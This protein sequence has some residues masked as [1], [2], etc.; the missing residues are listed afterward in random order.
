MTSITEAQHNKNRIAV[1][2]TYLFAWCGRADILVLW[3][4]PLAI[5]VGNRTWHYHEFLFI[6]HHRHLALDLLT[7]YLAVSGIHYAWRHDYEL[8]EQTHNLI[9]QVAQLKQLEGS[10]STY[11]KGPFPKYLSEIGK[12][13]RTACHFDIMVDCLDYGSF[14]APEVHQRVHNNI[15]MAAKKPGVTIR[16]LV[17]GELPEPFTGPSGQRLREYEDHEELLKNYSLMLKNDKGFNGFLQDLATSATTTFSEFATTWFKGNAPGLPLLEICRQ[18]C[19]INVDA[20]GSD[21]NN[22]SALTADDDGWQVL[23]TLLQIRQFWFARDLRRAGVEIRAY[24]VADRQPASTH[25]SEPIFFWIKYKKKG[26]DKQFISKEREITDDALFTFANAARG[27][28]QLGYSTHDEDLLNT[29]RAIFEDN[30]EQADPLKGKQPS[31]LTFLKK[32]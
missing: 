14:F 27:K 10:L 23:Q 20:G 11:R 31:W 32:C 1:L 5:F 2:F 3:F 15:C 13:A 17:C 22:T 25:Q 18:V 28:G 30:W 6:V 16:I 29:F 8:G 4:I 19:A 12:L 21:T 24:P 7:I 26:V 9:N